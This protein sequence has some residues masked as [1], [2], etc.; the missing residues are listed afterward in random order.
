LGFRG[1]GLGGSAVGVLG[2]SGWFAEFGFAH[3]GRCWVG[4]EMREGEVESTRDEWAGRI[5]VPRKCGRG[6]ESETPGPPPFSRSLKPPHA[7]LQVG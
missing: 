5:E 7:N 4:G 2:T 3:Y 6:A 1:R